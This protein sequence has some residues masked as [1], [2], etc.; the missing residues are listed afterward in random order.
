MNMAPGS[1]SH[2][3]HH[4]VL[5]S[6]LSTALLFGCGVVDP[7]ASTEAPAVAG[8]STTSSSTP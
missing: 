5:S 4:F 1:P 8:A 2:T 6:L 7:L 3:V